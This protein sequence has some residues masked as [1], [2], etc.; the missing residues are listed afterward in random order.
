MASL[1]KLQAKK[2]ANRTAEEVEEGGF[3]PVKQK[4]LILSSR[5]ITARHRFLIN[6]L[7]ALIPHSKKDTKLD[8]KQK[9][10]QLN[11]VAE[12]YNCNNIM[13]FEARKHQDLY[14]WL[15]KPPNGPSFKL[16][17]QNLHTMDELNLTGNCLKGSRP[18]LSFDSTFQTK[19]H[20]RVLQE[21]LQQQF[22]V[23]KGARRSKPFVDHI[24]TLTIADNKIWF[25]NY[26]IAETQAKDG[27]L[28]DG[29]KRKAA[30]GET[31]IELI[32]VGPRFCMTLICVLEGSFG[33]PLI[34]ENKEYVSPNVVRREQ[35][36]EKAE[37]Y[38]S[39]RAQ[40]ED[41]KQKKVLS[42]RE[43]GELDNA[44]LFK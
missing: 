36:Q 29:T 6:D 4:V 5:G 27:V 8:T 1:Y 17:I 20:F 19:P 31:E 40:T 41:L 32:E 7:T 28:E 18:I 42:Q 37:A 11:E 34:Y 10:F 30:K 33:G 25:R 24:L 14:V 35:R 16:H 26:Q 12:L 43:K 2:G 13:F 22:G 21:L 15:S 44:V 9:L 3:K 39:R 23:P 38:K